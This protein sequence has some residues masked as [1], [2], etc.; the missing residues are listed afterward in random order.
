MLA[1]KKNENGVIHQLDTKDHAKSTRW[2][3]NTFEIFAK[4]A[5][6]NTMDNSRNKW[7]VGICPT[8]SLWLPLAGWGDAERIREIEIGLVGQKLITWY[9]DWLTRMINWVTIVYNNLKWKEDITEAVDRTPT[10]SGSL[11]GRTDQTAEAETNKI[12]NTCPII[13]TQPEKVDKI[14]IASGVG[15][16]RSNLISKTI[17]DSNC[18]T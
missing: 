2:W 10:R 11:T 1:R 18:P 8:G 4:L 16:P 5:M 3:K 12:R 7:D 14:I 17:F 6:Q 13:R 15:S 9:N